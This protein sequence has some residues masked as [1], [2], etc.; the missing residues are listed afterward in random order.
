MM[1]W[2]EKRGIIPARLYGKDGDIIVRLAFDTGATN[3]MI[4]WD[5]AELLGYDPAAEKDRIRIT[6]TANDPR[7]SKVHPIS[8]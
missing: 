5:I 6:T 2:E 4:N 3:S 1:S 8:P 7:F